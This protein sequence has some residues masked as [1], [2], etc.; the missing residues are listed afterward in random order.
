M[1]LLS[2]THIPALLAA[3]AL[4]S[5]SAAQSGG[6][7]TGKWI[8]LGPES[9][10]RNMFVY[11]RKSFTLAATPKSAPA[12][13]AAD[14][15]YKLFVNGRYVGRGPARF[16]AS[17]LYFDVYDLAPYLRR[18]RNVVAMLVWHYGVPT[19]QTT[20]APAGI[21]FDARIG[22]L[23]L[24]SDGS[25][26][27]SR[28]GAWRQDTDKVDL[29][30]PCWEEFDARKEIAGWDAPAFDDRKWTP[31]AV[32]GPAGSAPWLRLRPRDIPPLRERLGPPPAVLET[33][34]IDPKDDAPASDPLARRMQAEALKPDAGSG[35]A[36]STRPGSDRAGS[37]RAASNGSGSNGSGS[38]L[39][40][41]PVLLFPAGAPRYAV[42]DFGR[43]VSGYPRLTVEAP[44]GATV[45]MGYSELLSMGR[46]LPHRANVNYADR[47]ICRK[48]RQEHELFAPRAFRYMQIDVRNAAGPIRVAVRLNESGYPVEYRGRFVC[49][50]P[51]L[52]RIWA[53]GRR[54][55][56]LCMDDGYMDCPWRE[57]GQWWGDSRV[58][59]ITTYY[60][61]GDA[62]L[63]RRAI[64]QIGQ[65]QRED[66]I[67]PG[68]Y[69]SCF[70]NR[71]LPDFCLIWVL[72]LDDYCRHTGD[73]SLAEQ[74]WP[75]VV[76]SLNY[77]QQF[78][79][80][81]G[82]LRDVPGWVFIDWADVDKGG[83]CAALNAYYVG[84]LR[85]AAAIA[86]RIG[87][88]TE[89]AGY[90]RKAGQVASAWNARFWSETDGAYVDAFDKVPSRTVSEQ[91]N[92]LAILFGIAPR[93]RWDSM[94]NRLD[95]SRTERVVRCGSPYFSFYWL[96]AM[97]RAG[98]YAQALDY[99]RKHYGVMLRLGATSAW[100]VW[101][102]GSSLCHGW[103]SG[104]TNL[105]PAYV[106][107]IQ[108]ESD[109]WRS[110]RIAPHLCDLQSA[111]AV[112]PTPLGDV[113]ARWTVT[114][115]T[116]TEGEVSLPQGVTGWIC[117]GPGARVSIDGRR[118]PI[119]SRN[120]ETG[121]VLPAGAHHVAIRQ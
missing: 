88:R 110:V 3:L 82:L 68:V 94:F 93:E 112:V 79:D 44:A 36:A 28:A 95:E 92:A 5:A 113:E 6:R 73:L 52:N 118:A 50:D 66:G 45:D 19:F 12:R 13:V 51:Q 48:G 16:Q 64:A 78:L 87:R 32:L 98:R 121:C 8:W 23:A 104:P 31:A 57:R 43:E 90:L 70:E 100:E 109:G 77:F 1:R 101:N 42:L 62:S 114:N 83:E 24:G 47:L 55:V 33:G 53:L 72:T 106:V 80:A 14:T 85:A 58:E 63:V 84:A 9:D 60:A 25:W 107:G 108:P 21:L 49:S 89:A 86:D 35:R 30:Q 99:T 15:R 76:R 69:P 103:S 54:T 26:R 59:G 41:P 102:M 56:E 105:L 91:T 111:L 120:G 27:L 46:V 75:R 18:G 115:Q 2:R 20:E 34:A 10:P 97:N 67:T 96:W 29:Q 22:R 7:W 74:T 119:Q 39:A 11:A 4:S 116:N 61:F 37:A 71:W 17:D 40:R 65:G 81:A 117:I 38:N